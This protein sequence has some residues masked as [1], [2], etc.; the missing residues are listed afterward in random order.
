MKFISTLPDGRTVEINAP[1]GATQEQ[2]DIFAIQEYRR[3]AYGGAEKELSWSDV[4]GE[5]VENI[6]ESGKRLAGHLYEAVTSPV[7]TVDAITKIG[8]GALQLVLPESLVNAIG[9]DEQSIE[10]ARK[11]G[12]FFVNRY[13]DEESIKK[14]LAEDPVGAAAD[15]A[16]VLTLGGGAIAKAGT[17]STVSGVSKIG[18]GLEAVGKFVDPVVNTAKA[19]GYIP[20]LAVKA[21]AAALG[22]TTGVGTDVIVE[23]FKASAEGGARGKAFRDA[24]RGEVNLAE[25]VDDA[26]AALAGM[27]EKAANAYKQNM[28]LIKADSSVLSFDDIYSALDKAKEQFAMFG[29]QVKVQEAVTALDQIR[30]KVD[31]WAKGDPAVFATPYGLDQLKQSIWNV[32]ETYSPGKTAANKTAQMAAQSVYDAVKNTISKQAP[33]YAEIM[34]DYSKAQDDINVIRQ[35]LSLKPGAM[36]DT[37]LR[38][39][40]SVL[41]DNVNTN[42]SQRRQRVDVLEAEGAN[43]VPKIAGSQLSTLAPRGSARFTGGA[44]TG[45]AYAGTM[46]PFVALGTAATASPRVAGEA[47]SIAGQAAGP[48]IK[49][50]RAVGEAG[51]PLARPAASLYDIISDPY[52]L[53]AM[54]QQQRVKEQ[55]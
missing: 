33:S 53:G 52:A 54:L 43:I 9:K 23:A 20:K 3:G 25:I 31:D 46:N 30:K 42:Y 1:E 40:M 2:A 49:G 39:L 8:A 10:M 41:R 7:Q 34:K 13:G 28:E 18:Q 48:F 17:V 37:S 55:Q 38:K 29:G 35:E 6:P 14:T 12:E 45:L 26:N 50:A 21:P 27:Q 36:P 24:M 15:I 19:L 5:A 32:V 11:V 44:G 16:S 22:V 51:K 4:P 47:A